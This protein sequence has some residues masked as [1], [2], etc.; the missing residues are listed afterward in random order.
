MNELNYIIHQIEND[1]K[2]PLDNAGIYYRIFARQKSDESIKDKLLL[3]EKKYIENALKMQDIIG[4]RIVL[5]FFDDV[6]II[7]NFLHKHRLYIDESDTKK[8]IDNANRQLG[9]IDLTDKIF[10]PTRLNLIFKLEDSHDKELQM[11]LNSGYEKFNTKLIDST[12]EIQLRTVLSEGWHEVEHDLRYKTKDE[13][14]WK[15]C[16]IESRMLNGIYA[17]LETS[18]RALGH[19]FSIIAH[20]NYCSKEWSAM[21]RNHFRIRTMDQKLSESLVEILNEDKELAKRIFR[22]ERRMLVE[23]LLDLNERFPLILDNILYL[24]NRLLENPSKKIQEKESKVISGILDKYP[25]TT[26]LDK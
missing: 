23:F 25:E 14:W 10:M 17:T 20:K 4:V 21:L 9:N 7:N 22:I 6:E 11:A 3:K 24:S 18:E 12:Y 5:Y 26:S 15:D 8:D 13:S 16:D 1:L 19:V 2:K